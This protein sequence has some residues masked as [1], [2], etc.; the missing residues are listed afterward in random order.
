MSHALG[1]LIL[2]LGLVLALAVMAAERW[3][4]ARLPATL[5]PEFLLE[6]QISPPWSGLLAEDIRRTLIRH[7][8][9][10]DTEAAA[11]RLLQAAEGYPLD[12]QLWMSLARL[13]AEPGGLPAQELSALLELAT[14]SAPRS[15]ST[16]F[17]AAQMAMLRADFMAADQ[18]L[19][20]YLAQSPTA[21]R[22]VLRM[23]SR[24]HESA[25]SL[26][27]AIL[28]ASQASWEQAMRTAWQER[29]LA[30]AE[31]LWAAKD[32]A[33]GL[34]DAF[35]LNYIDTLLRAGQSTAAAA[36]W[37]ER[38]PYYTQG[39]VPNWNFGRALGS[40]RGFNW[41]QNVPNGVRLFRDLGVFQTSPA[42]LRVLF[43]GTTNVRLDAP[44]LQIP[45]EPD[46]VYV[47]RG[48]WRAE[49]LGTRSLP[50]LWLRADH[51]FEDR[52]ADLPGASF[53]WTAWE[54]RFQTTPSTNQVRLSLRRDASRDFDSDI[55]G[56]LWID[57]IRLERLGPSDQV[58]ADD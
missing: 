7:W 6:T 56:T 41:R 34:D 37:R 19:Q 17:D 45:V 27:A 5:T 15:A 4:L 24:W 49:Q 29:D 9:A 39:H 13:A 1:R 3:A 20:S 55:S 16:H 50:Y 18:H 23:A 25:D 52:R 28:P 31:A 35:F 43:D 40:S 2:V 44:S 38:D 48:Y 36:A 57:S 14:A 47:L 12:A 22:D 11:P 8:R 58:S 21:T 46:S 51:G 33:V 42:S 26:V 53:D 32:F 54:I 10:L 30:L